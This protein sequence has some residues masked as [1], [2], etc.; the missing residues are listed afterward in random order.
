MT[1]IV[2]TVVVGGLL[3]VSLAI[4]LFMIGV[5]L[6]R[7]AGNLGD[8]LDNLRIIAGQAQVVGPGLGRLNKTGADLLGA[9]PLLVEGAEAVAAKLAPSSTAPAA[10]DAATPTGFPSGATSSAAPLLT[11]HS[12]A[13]TDAAADTP[14]AVRVNGGL[15]DSPMGVGYLDA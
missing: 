6:N 15:L 8:C 4:Y 5:L 3:I 13:R 1:L 2:M 11:R 12:A 10:S 9:M 14:D 7:T